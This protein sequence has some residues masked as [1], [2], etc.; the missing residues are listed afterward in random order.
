VGQSYIIGTSNFP[1]FNWNSS[2]SILVIIAAAIMTTSNT[3]GQF[4]AGRF[5]LGVGVSVTG[6]AAPAYSIEISLPQVNKVVPV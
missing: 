3:R 6:V 5:V 2:G 1:I 4:L